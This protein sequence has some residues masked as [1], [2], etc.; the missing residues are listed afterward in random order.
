MHEFLKFRVVFVNFVNLVILFAYAHE[1]IEKRIFVIFV[2]LALLFKKNK[3]EPNVEVRLK[4]TKF[5]ILV[6]FAFFG[7]K[8][9]FFKYGNI[10]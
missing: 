5:V 2:I 8:H 10:A 7:I 6:V 1:D 9:Q 3:H 4:I